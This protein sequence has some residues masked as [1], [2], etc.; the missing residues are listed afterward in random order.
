MTQFIPAPRIVTDE[1]AVCAE[2][3]GGLVPWYFGRT[4]YEFHAM[5]TIYHPIPLNYILRGLLRLRIWWNRFRSRPSEIDEYIQ[6][7]VRVEREK[8]FRQG[9]ERGM[10]RGIKMTLMVTQEKKC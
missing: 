10:E 5:R 6:T 1:M 8:A 9:E 2:D 7:L 4:C 3:V